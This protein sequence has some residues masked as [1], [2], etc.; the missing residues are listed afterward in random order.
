V[1]CCVRLISIEVEVGE[2]D[3]A[4]TGV[5][6]ATIAEADLVVSAWLVAVT[7]YVPAVAGAL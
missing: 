7:V 6:T 5:V 4:T 1:N 2:M 3:T